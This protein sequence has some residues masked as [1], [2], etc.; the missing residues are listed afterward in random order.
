MSAWCLQPGGSKAS[1][2]PSA[3]GGKPHRIATPLEFETF[4]HASVFSLSLFLLTHGFSPITKRFG[5][6]TAR[7]AAEP[8]KWSGDQT[9]NFNK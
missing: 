4:V 7:H 2:Y 5:S 6:P 8:A 3:P 1:V 9:E